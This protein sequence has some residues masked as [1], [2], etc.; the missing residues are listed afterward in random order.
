M[1]DTFFRI[2]EQFVVRFVEEGYVKDLNGEHF[3]NT[4][5]GRNRASS[6]NVVPRWVVFDGTLPDSHFDSREEAIDAATKLAEEG[7]HC[8]HCGGELDPILT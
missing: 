2:N 5:E 3:A 7:D 8:P 1:S 4:P 6:F